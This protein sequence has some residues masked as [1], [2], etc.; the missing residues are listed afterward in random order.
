MG[1]SFEYAI[2]DLD[3]PV[4]KAAASAQKTFYDMYNE[5]GEFVETYPSADAYKEAIEELEDF[6]MVDT[7]EYERKPRVVIG[8]FEDA[9]KRLHDYIEEYLEKANAKQALYFIGGDS[10]TNFRHEK[11]TIIGYKST[12]KQ[13]KPHHFYD[14][15]EYAKLEFNPVIAEG[16]ECDDLVSIALYEDYKRGLKSKDKSVC[17]CVLVSIDK[18]S[19]V[20]PGWHLN[21]DKD[22]EPVWISTKDAAMWLYT[23]CIGGDTA[24]AIKGAPGYGYKKAEKALADCK[25]ESEL[26]EKT[27]EIYDLAYRKECRKKNRKD[28]AL[29]IDD[30]GNVTYTTYQGE[31]VT[32]HIG[33]LAE[34]N[35]HLV[36]MLRE[37]T[38]E[39]WRR[40][41]ER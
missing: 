14:L 16:V 32:K 37:S 4:Y 19:K 5:K 20:T 17:Q 34:E 7:S 18:D 27:C 8:E 26:W 21:P 41:N 23:M 33:D 22:D 38:D 30:D 1:R 12:R 10:S 24:D 11:A 25:N 39:R 9:V 35:M 2:I 28:P 36:Y 40:P 15:V 31:V 6:L 13:E 29:E 3:L